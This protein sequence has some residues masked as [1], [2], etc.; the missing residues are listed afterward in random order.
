MRLSV[1][2]HGHRGRSRL[3]IWMLRRV[4]AGDVDI[5]KV[6]HH[7]PRFFG[8]EFFRLVDEVLRDPTSSWS[9][10]ERELFAGYTS[11]LNQCPF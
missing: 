7:R 9:V 5:E 1:L 11:R 3:F 4:G 6:M 2:E 10:G 8:R